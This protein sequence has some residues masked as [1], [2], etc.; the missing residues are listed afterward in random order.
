MSQCQTV[1]YLASPSR[2][3]PSPSVHRRPC[4]F[5]VEMSLPH[6]VNP[7]SQTDSYHLHQQKPPER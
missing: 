3:Y 2:S 5:R 1:L 7:I 4:Q 6:E